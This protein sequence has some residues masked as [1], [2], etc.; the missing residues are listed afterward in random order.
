MPQR[1]DLELKIGIFV[2]LGLVIL[3][4]IVFS[5]A[6]YRFFK[7]GFNIKVIFDYGGGVKLSS[8]VRLA[9]VGVGEVKDIRVYFDPVL[10]KT[11]V[12][13]S[14]WIEKN[15]KI[16]LDSKIYI[17][18]LGLFDD[19]CL[20]IIPSIN[21]AVTLKEADFLMG[22]EQVSMQ[23]VI[24]MSHKIALK[25]DEAIASLNLVL[26]KVKTGQGSLGKFLS[27]DTLYNDAEELFKDLKA[28]PWKL[29]YRPKEKK[30][31]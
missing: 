4:F 15:T 14:C 11:Q 8:P 30:N 13:F 5:I 20:D 16:P 21:Y 1:I 19:K 26:G 28:H 3:G 18:S 2:V 6:D 10:N 9:G 7:P 27:N 29:L 24:Q 25:L 23:D 31:K 12:E 22:E 17:E